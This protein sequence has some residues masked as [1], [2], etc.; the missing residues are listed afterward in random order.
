MYR[1]AKAASTSNA[2]RWKNTALCRFG[3]ATRASCTVSEY[4]LAKRK[5]TR[6]PRAQ[7]EGKP[8]PEEYEQLNGELTIY[9]TMAETPEWLERKAWRE[10]ARASMKA[11]HWLTKNPAQDAPPSIQLVWLQC[12]MQ[13]ARIFNGY[14]FKPEV[15]PESKTVN[16]APEAQYEMQQNAQA[17]PA[18]ARKSPIALQAA[19]Y[20]AVLDYLWDKIDI[21]G[22]LKAASQMAQWLD[23]AWVLDSFDADGCHLDVIDPDHV[24]YDPES[25]QDF[26]GKFRGRFL[27]YDVRRTLGYIKR[28]YPDYA[29]KVT[30][31]NT[32]GYKAKTVRGSMHD[33]DLENVT[34]ECWFVKDESTRK[35]RLPDSDKIV[36]DP[37]ELMKLVNDGY[38]VDEAPTIEAEVDDGQGGIISAPVEWTVYKTEDVLK[39][40]GGWRKIYRA[41][42]V[43]LNENNDEAFFNP[44]ASGELPLHHLPYYNVPGE[45]AGMSLVRQIKP[46]GDYIDLMA[47]EGL[48]IVRTLTPMLCVLD[49]RMAFESIEKPEGTGVKIVHFKPKAEAADMQTAFHSING[50]ELSMSYQ[51]MMGQLEQWLEKIAG[52]Y[53]LRDG[54][55]APR[56]PSGKFVQAVETVAN[57]RISELRENVRKFTRNIAINMLSNELY[58]GNDKKSYRTTM[59]GKQSQIEITGK[60]F[61][62]DVLERSFDLIVGGSDTLA[63]DPMMRNQQVDATVKNLLGYGDKDLAIGVLDLMEIDNKEDIRSVLETHFDKQAQAAQQSGGISPAEAQKRSE[64]ESDTLEDIGKKLADVAPVFSLTVARNLGNSK[65][66]QP[67]NYDQLLE[68]AAMIQTKPEQPQPTPQGGNNGRAN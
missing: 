12:Q 30:P 8:Y 45:F 4:K 21:Q 39:F 65:Q 20:N 2:A 26:D 46:L 50:A 60:H 66:G 28:H 56:D 37:A 31:D 27:R 25:I 1:L 44:S 17:M 57:A 35:E 49:G 3:T 59:G 29:Y 24:R 19:I 34:L 5:P 55:N 63:N 54:N 42:G 43:I 53:D 61:A 23:D 9:T 38:K 36:T 22:C 48:E 16:P 62:N 15:I 52:G 47:A 7:G 6:Q 40:P 58:Y 41:N 51:N 32:V 68:M 14:S 18:R 11:Q 67:I 33:E 13:L 64:A 10:S